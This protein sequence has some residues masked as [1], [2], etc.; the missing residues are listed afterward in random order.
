MT[1]STSNFEKKAYLI[2]LFQ[3]WNILKVSEISVDLYL[4]FMP[5]NKFIYNRSVKFRINLWGHCFSQNP[6]QTLQR[7]LPYLLINFHSRNICILVG[8]L[9][10]MMTS[11][12]H[13]VQGQ[14][15]FF[16]FGPDR[17]KYAN[18]IWFEVICVLIR[19]GQWVV[20]FCLC[21]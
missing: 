3:I 1:H 21:A 5:L 13:S 17:E 7:F 8:I 19:C 15:V 9:G 11:Y 6:N 2:F 18:Y 12:I 14:S 16:K 20:D 10:E 4:P